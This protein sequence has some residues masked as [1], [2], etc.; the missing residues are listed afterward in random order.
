[1]RHRSRRRRNIPQARGDPPGT[2]RLDARRPRLDERRAAERPDGSNRAAAARRGSRRAGLDGD[3]LRTWMT[4]LA[5]VSV[6]L[7]F[8]FLAALYLFLLWV[9]RSAKRDLG[10]DAP[11]PVP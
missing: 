6:A 4:T 9:V 2:R 11:P 3:R 8:G 5:P 10:S 1:M 7:K